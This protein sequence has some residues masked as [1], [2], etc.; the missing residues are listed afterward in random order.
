MR[1]T[2]GLIVAGEEVVLTVKGADFSSSQNVLWDGQPLPT[3]Y[4]DN[5][6]LRATV[7]SDKTAAPGT[8]T[9]FRNRGASAV[10]NAHPPGTAAIRVCVKI[11]EYGG[12]QP[13]TFSAG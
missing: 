5:L 12:G 13:G 6:T 8:A 11:F 2:P 7:G 4:V 9:L 3:T 1:V 10:R